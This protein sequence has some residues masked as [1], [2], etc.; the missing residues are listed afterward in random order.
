MSAQDPIRDAFGRAL[1]K[2]PATGSPMVTAASAVHEM[3]LSLVAGGFTEPQA[4][5]WTAHYVAA[6]G[7]G[8]SR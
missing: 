3:F 8:D 7:N 6:M 1:A 5:A 2:G 4:I